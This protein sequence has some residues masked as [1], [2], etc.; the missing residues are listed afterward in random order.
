LKQTGVL[1]YRGENGRPRVLGGED[2][3]EI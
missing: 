1:K 2:K 3:I